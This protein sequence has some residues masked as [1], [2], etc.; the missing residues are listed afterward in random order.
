MCVFSV[1]M[2]V[3]K[4]EVTEGQ[5]LPMVERNVNGYVG[6]EEGC[7]G[8]ILWGRNDGAVDRLYESALRTRRELGR[9]R[10][11]MML[12]GCA[13]DD[14]G[15][16]KDDM[17][18]SFERDN[19]CLVA[20][21]HEFADGIEGD[22]SPL[23]AIHRNT[24]RTFLRRRDFQMFSIVFNC[25]VRAKLRAVVVIDQWDR[26]PCDDPSLHHTWRSMKK[27]PHIMRIFVPGG[28]WNA[29]GHKAR[30]RWELKDITR[31]GPAWDD[32]RWI[33]HDHAGYLAFVDRLHMASLSRDRAFM[34]FLDEVNEGR[35]ASQ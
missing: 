12:R 22:D 34:K 29:W 1:V 4:F 35:S 5:L 17:L 15:M 28:D 10:H 9:E 14:Q 25:W 8:Q 3:R 30:P 27:C 13:T 19:A 2:S 20:H 18:R 24:I 31:I 16:F 32:Q 26:V 33:D 23:R 21:M 11:V 6:G 7:R